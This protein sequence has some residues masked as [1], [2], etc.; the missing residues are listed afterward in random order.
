[1]HPTIKKNAPLFLLV[2][3]A[4]FAFWLCWQTFSPG[5]FGYHHDDGIYAVT[6]K[7]LAIGQGYKIISHPDEMTQTK[8]PPLY[9]WLLSAV[10]RIQPHFPSNLR[11]LI[12]LSNVM[13]ILSLLIVW[14]YLVRCS[15]AGRWLALSVVALS[16]MNWRMLL[17]ANTTLSEPTYTVLL[18][19]ALWLCEGKVERHESL[20]LK[21][22]LGALIGLA[23]LTRIVGITLPA[24]LFLYYIIIRRR[25][26]MVVFPFLLAAAFTAAWGF[27]V[28]F[29]MTTGLGSSTAFYTS[30]L[31]DWTGIL[32]GSQSL[33]TVFGN[34][35]RMIIRNL[36]MLFPI[37]IPIICFGFSFAW[38]GAAGAKVLFAALFIWVSAFILIVHGFAKDAN[39]RIGLLHVYIL[40]FMGLHVFWPYTPYDRFLMP[41][42]PFFY[43]FLIKGCKYLLPSLF[44]RLFY[45]RWNMKTSLRDLVLA[46]MVVT[47]IGTGA[48]QYVRGIVWEL[49]EF[50]GFYR[51]LAL[52]SDEAYGW[53]RENTK[54]TDILLCYPDPL[55][56]LHTQRKAIS[57]KPLSAATK[58]EDYALS[59]VQH[60]D[61]S[62]LIQSQPN[63]SYET[64]DAYQSITKASESIL[65]RFPDVFRPVFQSSRGSVV[66]F[67]KVKKIAEP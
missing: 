55:Y 12:L 31:R 37:S 18:L 30:Y 19:A 47:V 49:P 22:L 40:C 6:A 34:C 52:E 57:L 35:L 51:E 17:L 53:I 64:R 27:W 3:L 33:V 7:S 60:Y 11:S 42:M 24:A 10:W 20:R 59:A 36:F 21:L 43:L 8:Y 54:P 41:L 25:P 50:N 32:A 5:T 1:M 15:Y 44:R 13:T 61:I 58:M 16:A 67:R 28:N 26:S 9:P 46:L 23:I 48:V 14:G 39:H 56:F 63:L 4:L 66:I 65:E 38:A 62:Y 29:N 2:L 45:T